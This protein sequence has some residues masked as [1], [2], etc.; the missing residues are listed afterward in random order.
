MKEHKPG[1]KF[2]ALFEL[3]RPI[4]HGEVIR[5]T[6]ILNARGSLWLCRPAGTP[7]PPKGT[8]E[9]FQ[10]LCIVIAD[11]VPPSA[12]IDCKSKAEWLAICKFCLRPV[13]DWVD[14]DW[15]KGRICRECEAK[16]EP[17]SPQRGEPLP[18]ATPPQ[19]AKAT[20][21]GPSNPLPGA[22]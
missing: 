13:S 21:D 16:Y 5:G 4:E 22:D 3:V 14:P 2:N 8:P 15:A 9:A 17:T 18:G 11:N 12:W 19:P 10:W 7:E 1:D 6:E 20:E